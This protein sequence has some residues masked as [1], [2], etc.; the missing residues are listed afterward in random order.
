MDFLNKLIKVFSGYVVVLFIFCLLVSG[1]EA[2]VVSSAKIKPV[3]SRW[4]YIVIHHSATKKGNASRFNTYH[5]RRGMR[6]GLAYHFVI[7]NGTAG[8]FDGQLEIGPRWKKQINGGHCRQNW[9]NNSGIGIC[10]VGNFNKTQVS[11]KQFSV[12][13]KLCRMLMDKYGI[14]VRNVVGHGEVKGEH[15]ECPGKY[16]PLRELK[17]ALKRPS[18]VSYSSVP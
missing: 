12:L 2:T 14:P 8:T 10:L 5:K 3:K 6:N 17:E 11:E 1:V 15:S 18:N 4:K 13:Y 9:V 7:N 16:F